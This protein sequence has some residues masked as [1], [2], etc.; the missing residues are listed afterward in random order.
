MI[1]I[2]NLVNDNG[3]KE[4]LDQFYDEFV[5]AVV[6]T[7]ERAIFERRNDQTF[8]MSIVKVEFWKK[9]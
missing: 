6:D 2:L 1:K 9:S 4:K 3:L 5:E 7:R 8:V